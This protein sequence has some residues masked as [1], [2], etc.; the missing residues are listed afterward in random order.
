MILD[1]LYIEIT[2]N[3]TIECEHCL[4]GDREN[5]NMSVETLDNILKQVK[6]VQILLLSGGE[7]L[8]A[9]DILEKLPK[10]IKKYKIRIG[11]IGIISNGTI[12]SK[13]H[14]EALQSLK[15]QCDELQFVLSSDLFHRLEWKRLGIE[16]K[17]KENYETYKNLFEMRKF[18]DDDRYKNVVLRLKGRAK[19]ITKERIFEITKN[20][21]IHY[22]FIDTNEEERQIQVDGEKVHGKVCIDVNGN[23]V[24]YS[25]T[26]EEE[27]MS[28][29][30]QYNEKALSL[31]ERLLDYTKNEKEK[32]VYQ[33]IKKTYGKSN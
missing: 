15:E 33:K 5:K 25:S 28:S 13:R 9:I 26:Y 10:L 3:C 8:M 7:P 27:D 6:Q 32:K 22:Q 1:N 20:E 2:R 24:G 19:R 4:R 29:K 17:V 31:Q 23:I 12:C 11:I 18:L 16:E 21:Y 14:I 30:K